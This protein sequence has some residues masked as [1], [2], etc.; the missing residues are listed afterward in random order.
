MEI[1]L[2]FEAKENT[3]QESIKELYRA[4]RFTTEQFEKEIKNLRKI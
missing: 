3:K 4:K 1:R 2:D